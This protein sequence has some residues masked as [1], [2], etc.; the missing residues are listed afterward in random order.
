MVLYSKM[1]S[2]ENFSRTSRLVKVSSNHFRPAIVSLA[3]R[4]VGD[5]MMVAELLQADL[6][7]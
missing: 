2:Q 3:H 5:F 1:V 4:D 7:L 6:Y